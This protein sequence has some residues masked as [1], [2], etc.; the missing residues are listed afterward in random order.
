MNE[1]QIVKSFDQ[2]RFDISLS[3]R[4]NYLNGE[5]H[6]FFSNKISSTQ[7][8]ELAEADEKEVVQQLQEFFGDY[9][10]VSKESFSLNL[11][12]CL[13]TSQ[14][15]WS[16]MQTRIVEGISSCLLSLRKQPTIRYSA[17][18]DATS[19]IILALQRRVKEETLGLFDFKKKQKLPLCC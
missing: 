4:K 12:N 9:Y 11:E 18:S 17:Q 19:K 5:Y 10:A 6:L 7:I 8:D 13:S 16:V 15:N 1:R 3:L 14:S 2:I